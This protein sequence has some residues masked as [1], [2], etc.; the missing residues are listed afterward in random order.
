MKYKADLKPLIGSQSLTLKWLYESNRDKISFQ[1]AIFNNKKIGS[2]HFI[3]T[4]D[5]DINNR[6]K[7][8]K[9]KSLE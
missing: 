7:T 6:C 9:Q 3:D 5:S 2:F 1:N 4:I 8:I